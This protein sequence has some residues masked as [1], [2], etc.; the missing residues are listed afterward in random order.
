MDDDYPPA[1]K[2]C[3]EWRAKHPEASWTACKRLM[4]KLNVNIAEE[5]A[6]WIKY[7]TWS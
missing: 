6:H 7:R 1:G 2:S 5:Q 4:Q 3:K